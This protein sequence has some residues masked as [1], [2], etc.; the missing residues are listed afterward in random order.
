[1]VYFDDDDKKE[2]CNCSALPEKRQSKIKDE[3]QIRTLIE[4]ENNLHN[5]VYVKK[6]AKI[7]LKFFKS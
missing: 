6:Y 1:M 4:F 2:N 7:L 3:Q 5:I